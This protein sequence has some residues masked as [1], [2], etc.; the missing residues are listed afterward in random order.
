MEGVCSSES[1]ATRRYIQGDKTL[2]TVTAVRNSI[3]IHRNT[4]ASSG[5]ETFRPMHRRGLLVMPSFYV[6]RA[7]NAHQFHGRLQL[8]RVLTLSM[9]R[10]EAMKLVLV[11]QMSW[12]VE[13]AKQQLLHESNCCTAFA[14]VF[15]VTKN[16]NY[17]FYSV[18]YLEQGWFVSYQMWAYCVTICL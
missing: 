13:R 11:M 2:V 7:N 10:A 18:N 4:A 1:S 12:S 3:F 9:G 17:L 15:N 14:V 8:L 16:M 6:L 5:D